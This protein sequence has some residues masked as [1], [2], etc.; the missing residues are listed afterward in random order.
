MRRV[1]PLLARA[2]SAHHASVRPPSGLCVAVLALLALGACGPAAAQDGVGALT[3]AEAAAG[4]EAAGVVRPAEVAAAAQ[5]ASATLHQV[6]AR[7]HHVRDLEHR[8]IEIESLGR[9]VARLREDS[10]LDAL[11]A[12]PVRELRNLQEMWT[13]LDARVAEVG[14]ALEETATMLGAEAERVEA[15]RGRWAATAAAAAEADYP[16]AARTRI[17]EVV[18]LVAA[19]ALDLREHLEQVLGAQTRLAAHGLVTGDVLAQLDRAI[20][21]SQARVLS[22]THPVGLGG[23]T[24]R[25]ATPLLTQ[26]SHALTHHVHGLD[27]FVTHLGGRGYVHGVV[28]FLLLAFLYWLRR[29]HR[30]GAEHAAT[31]SLSHPV[32]T[33]LFVGLFLVRALHPLAPRAVVELAQLLA[34]APL[35]LLPLERGHRRATRLTAVLYAL[36]WLRLLFDEHD[37]EHRVAL[38]A[39]A[40]LATGGLGACAR[41][42]AGPGRAA[43]GCASAA[44]AVGV[45]AC[46]AGYVPL[47][48]ILVEGAI[49]AAFIAMALL[50]LKLSAMGWVDAA[51]STPLWQSTVLGRHADVTRLAFRRATQ[52]LFGLGWLWIALDYFRLRAA[53]RAQLEQLL[54]ESVH[55]GD[56]E[57]SVGEVLAF[58]GGIWAAVIVSRILA[59]TLQED[60]APRLEM[61][62]GVPAAAALIVRYTVLALG[63]V[64]AASAAGIGL[65]Q[66]A[67]FAGAL[68]V[69]VG[70]GLQNIVSNFVS[71]LLLVFERP[72]KV[73]DT[74]EVSNVRGTVTEIGI[75][76]ST[77]RALNGADIIIPNSRM[78][79]GPLVNWTHT[80]AT[81]RVDFPIGVAYGSDVKATHAVLMAAAQEHPLALASPAASVLLTA[82]GD[83][84]IDFEVRIWIA[85]ATKLPAARSALGMALHEAL[86]RAGI[87]IPFPQRVVHLRNADA[88]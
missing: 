81:Q 67:L 10:D 37:A 40:I 45:G 34:I 86:E 13:T 21:E 79:E 62:P 85:D 48:G 84:S 54:A 63:F 60:V 22:R 15:I 25:A 32:A 64:L 19:V 7:I 8:L 88:D 23:A 74:V 29:E 51:L 49:A 52:L 39:T 36:D 6:R 33:T 50:A 55:L 9:E 61:G 35:L 24:D 17:G 73:G 44:A 70:F 59:R 12:Q 41:A 46:L 57:I 78:I 87:E 3:P 2:R 76:S 83:S 11:E 30:L 38:L 42:S 4:S 18:E 1:W 71:G 16:D 58:V 26:L 72:V 75:R 68:G 28:V 31:A 77:V 43:W 80:D 27:R 66:L 53:F 47:A 82:F 14:E 65:S 20:E 56:I 69:G 5:Q